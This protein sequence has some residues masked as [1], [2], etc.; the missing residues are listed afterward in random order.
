MNSKKD[1]VLLG[2]ITPSSNTAL[3]PVTARML[4][5]LPEVSVHAG[6]FRVTEISLGAGALGQFD[7][8]PMLAA[9]DLLADAHCSAIC[10]NGTSAGWLG[11]DR[12]RQLCAEIE[13]RTGI[14]ATSAVLALLDAF[15]LAGITRYGLVTP[16]TEDI[17]QAIIANFARSGFECVAERHAGIRVNFDFSTI[18]PAA[19]ETMLAEVVAARPQ[20]VVILCTNMDGAALAED[21]E[22]RSGVLLLDSIAFAAWGTLRA[23]GVDTRRVRGW[24]KLFSLTGA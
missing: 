21:F 2:M 1:R 3:E 17:Q 10:W 15:R 16:Y 7:M 9:A 11:F 14:R 8:A 23:A 19:I 22:H 5:G 12:D 4:A 24:G 6:R 13:H 18:E 20:A